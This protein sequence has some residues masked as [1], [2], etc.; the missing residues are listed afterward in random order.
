MYLPVI[1]K[2]TQNGVLTSYQKHYQMFHNILK[3]AIIVSCQKKYQ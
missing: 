2:S 3:E 1:L